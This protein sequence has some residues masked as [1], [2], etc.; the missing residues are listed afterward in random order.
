MKKLLLLILL[1][2]SLLVFS[3]KMSVVS[4]KKLK[5]FDART[6][7]PKLDHNGE[8]C[9]IIKVKT[10]LKGLNFVGD[11]NGVI[12]VEY[13][14]G[15][16]W[17]YVPYGSRRINISHDNFEIL[18]YTYPE[19]IKKSSSYELALIHGNIKTIIQNNI[20]SQ[21]LII[22]SEPKGA[23]VY[24]NNDPKGPTPF[25]EKVALG[26]Y[27]C[28]LILPMY[29]N[30]DSIIKINPNKKQ[31]IMC[32][33]KPAFGYLNINST[34]EQGAKV[35]IDGKN[36]KLI[37][38]CKKYKISSGKHKIALLHPNFKSKNSWITVKDNITTPL[39]ILMATALANVKINVAN[40][41]IIFIN[42]EKKGK[43]IWNG[44]LK[45]GI[46]TVETKNNK[47]YN[48]IKEINI[49]ADVNTIIE[50]EPI[51]KVGNIDIDSEPYEAKIYIDGKFS[52]KTP[53][54]IINL[55]VGKHT[56]ELKKDGYRSIHKTIQIT[57]NFTSRIN[58]ILLPTI[59]AKITNIFHSQKMSVVSFKKLKD[60]DARTEY[61]KLDMNDEKCAIIK[62]N[63]GFKGLNFVGDAS[64]IITVEYKKGE[65]WVY[66]PSGSRRIVISHEDFGTLR[67]NYPE[68][69]KKSTSYELKLN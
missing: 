13:K 57:E 10:A 17:V 12:T 20:T 14:K 30:F 43:G 63:T 32:K 41:L 40:N 61:P 27:I 6:E 23:M 54:I 11:A 5:D 1:T 58:E 28:K 62:V 48:D 51:T 46:Y 64:G 35:Y 67:Y 53:N 44:Q 59:Q 9:A 22:K 21:Y 37:T 55:I 15:E 16:I 34:P 69:I 49:I 33:L 3:Q 60:F 19:P 29:H 45:E 68:P 66:V 56:L 31:E 42:G 47:Y 36:T 65:I 8:K 26:K 25:K 4:F 24:I 50:L 39:N 2:Q 38:P 7:Y 52:G 18:R